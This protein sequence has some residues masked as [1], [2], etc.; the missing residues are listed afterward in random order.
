MDAETTPEV[1]P[2]IRTRFAPS[3]T[4]RL[5]IGSVRAALFPFLFAKHMGGQFVLR[6]EDTDRTRST[7]DFERDILAGLA[8]VGILWDEGPTDP[9]KK[10]GKGG[11]GPYRQTE[12]MSIYQK[13]IKKMLKLGL[14]YERNGAIWFRIPAERRA[15]DAN[16][17][18]FYDLVR[19]EVSVPTET[20]EDFVIVK[21]DG[22]PL[23]LLTNVIDDHE[24]QITHAI[25][26]EDHISNTPKQVLIAEA[27]GLTLPKY[28]HLPLILNPDRSKMSKRVGN[29]ALIE[30][31]EDGYLPEAIVNFL[32]LLGWAPGDDRE[33]FTTEELIQAFSLE[34]VGKSGSVFNTDKLDY[35]NAYYIRHTEVDRLAELILAD[36][37]DYQVLGKR[38]EDMDY[39][40]AVILLVRDRM[41]KLSD[42]P[43]LVKY[44]FKA[45]RFGAQLL[46]FKKSDKKKTLQGL[47]LVT[48]RLEE[49]SQSAWTSIEALRDILGFTVQNNG[50]TNGDVFW[51]V[52]VALSG[53]EASPSPD[54]LLFILG[55]DESIE[56]LKIAHKELLKP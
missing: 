27:L 48:K 4:G 33:V 46:I 19:G 5:H 18:R 35:I 31:K 52:R 29:T 45:P 32:A 23:F 15:N 47:V 43:Q 6:I 7:K 22:T 26:G 13:Y 36:F 17:I 20:I 9:E 50:L 40:K 25:R 53:A 56:R 16:R 42:F 10:G 1:N 3:P 55:R 37:W 21:S 51:P 30:F 34:R 14:A 38:P 12:R 2:V 8:W 24:M 11:F 54:E 41:T 39:L 44:F 28:A 49:A